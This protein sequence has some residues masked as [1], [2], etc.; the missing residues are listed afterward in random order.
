MVQMLQSMSQLLSGN[1]FAVAGMKREDSRLAVRTLPA[2]VPSERLQ[3]ADADRS[4]PQGTN[5]RG[6][7]A[8]RS[9]GLGGSP[10]SLRHPGHVGAT[11][12]TRSAYP[13]ADQYPPTA[14]RGGA[15]VKP[16]SWCLGRMC[17][18]PV[19]TGRRGPRTRPVV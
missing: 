4:N 3:P 14:T 6:L 18:T 15:L 9:V 17:P 16:L 1:G 10:L 13:S 7:R 11:C 8:G 19:I 2:S 5:P 12:R